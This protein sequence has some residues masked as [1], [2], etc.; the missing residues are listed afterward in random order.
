MIILKEASASIDYQIAIVLFRE[1]A[2]QIG[3]DLGFQNFNEEI[4]TIQEQYARPEG[5]IFIVYGDKNS[6]IG[7]FGIRA[8]DSSIC[9]LKRMY[10][11]KEARGNGTGKLMILKAISIAKELGYERMRL[12]TLPTM[13]TAIDLY[14][15]IGFYKIDPYRFNPIEG[16]LYF[17][18]RL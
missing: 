9:E 4:E 18:I 14:K 16:A 15:K 13:Q 12:D 7:C 2:S 17:E 10:L 11:K 6:P 1:Y 8:L 3:I 5:G